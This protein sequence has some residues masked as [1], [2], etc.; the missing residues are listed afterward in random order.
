MPSI[1][2]MNDGELTPV[3][4]STTT[5]LLL[6]DE[7]EKEVGNV[8][9][10]WSYMENKEGIIELKRVFSPILGAGYEEVFEN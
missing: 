4:V 9:Q 7:D 5:G 8:T 3:E 2:L 6:G 10:T 1:P